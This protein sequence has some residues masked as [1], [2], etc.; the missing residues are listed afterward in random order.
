MKNQ[1]K[2]RYRTL[3]LRYSPRGEHWIHRI[4]SL[5]GAK[6]VAP[7]GHEGAT[8]RS[9]KSNEQFLTYIPVLGH[10]NQLQAVSSARR[11]TRKILKNHYSLLRLRLANCGPNVAKWYQIG[12]SSMWNLMT[13]ILPKVW[14]KKST[15]LIF[16]VR[17][18]L[19]KCLL[20]NWKMLINVGVKLL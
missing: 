9:P 1:R 20:Q 2:V 14:Q 4:D 10:S 13:Q 8:C 5:C 6:R 12:D 11:S 16:L 3:Q 7:C 15:K 19:V 18:K 17:L